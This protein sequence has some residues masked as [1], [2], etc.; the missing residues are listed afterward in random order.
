MIGNPKRRDKHTLLTAFPP[1][2][3]TVFNR[4]PQLVGLAV[5]LLAAILWIDTV[6]AADRYLRLGVPP[7][8]WPPYIIV[9]QDQTTGIAIEV[10]TR[11]GAQYGYAV[12]I[13]H[14]PE[15]RAHLMVVQGAIDAW[16]DAKEWC[17]DPQRFLWTDALIE[18]EDRLICRKNRPVT[19]QR[20]EDLFG[21]TIG[22][23]LGYFYPRL[24]PYFENER[25]VR[26]DTQS[27]AAM[28]KM[29][30]LGRTDAA[31]VNQLV[32]LWIIKTE[33]DLQVSDFR[34]C[35]RVVDRAGYRIMFTRQH[36]WRPFIHDFNSE[37]KA[38]K[39]DG[40]LNRIIGAYR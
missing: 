28:L 23:H 22:T 10:I 32:A 16:F 5:S 27:E 26:A 29:L 33:P 4:L 31:V 15:K 19:F 25:I 7:H 13:D 1:G 18:S 35:E 39:Q 40:R 9:D 2:V 20:I 34:F 12:V 6:D 24:D 30:A 37:L 38:M 8:G 11:I 36:D 3:S 17:L 21:K 14:Y